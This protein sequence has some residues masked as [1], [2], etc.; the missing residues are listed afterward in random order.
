[1]TLQEI[2]VKIILILCFSALRQG[3]IETALIYLLLSIA[4]AAV[5]FILGTELWLSVVLIPAFFLGFIALH[6]LVMVILP[7]FIDKDNPP[8]NPDN[9]FRYFTLATLSLL[10]GLFRVKLEISGMEKL[11]TEKFLL[12]GNHQSVFDPM[13]EMLVFRKH[14]LAFVSKKENLQIPI[15]GKY[16]AASGC[17][18]LDRENN[19]SAG[20]VIEKAASAVSS[21]RMSMGIYPEGGT[22]KKPA[23]I[24]LMPLHNGS[25][26]C[27]LKAKAPVAV[28]V[29]KNSR[30]LEKRFFKLRTVISLEIAAVI[31][32]E[33][34]KDMKTREISEKAE[35]IMLAA[36][37][38]NEKERK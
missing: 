30:G 34:I 32:F 38:R 13:I 12:I 28:V 26:K 11:P 15:G 19:R 29:I 33:E 27:A 3:G 24:P 4:A 25:F 7:I 37:S 5:F 6:A 35:K 31:P 23:E 16:M 22:N 14:K 18:S 8:E 1:M 36:L 10:F 17:I 20:S 21:G 9:I 2:S